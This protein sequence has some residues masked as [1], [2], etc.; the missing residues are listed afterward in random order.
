MIVLHARLPESVICQ[1]ENDCPE[2]CENQ[3]PQI[4]DG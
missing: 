1:S 2:A 3:Q 4:S